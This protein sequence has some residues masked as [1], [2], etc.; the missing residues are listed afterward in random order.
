[1]CIQNA[2]G[3]RTTLST[4]RIVGANPILNAIR[5]LYLDG[6]KL[7]SLSMLR[8]RR[9]NPETFT[10]SFEDCRGAGEYEEDLWNYRKQLLW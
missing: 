8:L 4:G 2:T 10:P 7:F 9:I 3:S 5:N 6:C 1:M